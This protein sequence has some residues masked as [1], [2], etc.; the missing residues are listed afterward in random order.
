MR[1]NTVLC[2]SCTFPTPVASRSGLLR[3]AGAAASV[4]LF[5]RF[6]RFNI[7]RPLKSRNGV[8]FTVSTVRFLCLPLNTTA[9]T[10]G[11]IGGGV[12]IY[13]YLQQQFLS[14]LMISRQPHG[15]IRSSERRKDLHEGGVHYIADFLVFDHGVSPVY[16]CLPFHIS[17]R[18]LF[19]VFVSGSCPSFTGGLKF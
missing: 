2:S 18:F 11:V 12:T 15:S 8:L 13:P 14:S 10:K 5:R 19:V 17:I 4:S 6:C 7:F 9:F 1:C 3:V 16:V